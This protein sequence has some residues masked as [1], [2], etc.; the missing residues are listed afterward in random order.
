[1]KNQAPSK[2]GTQAGNVL[3]Y[4]LLAIFLL[5]ALTM[6]MS[7]TGSQS[8]DT[9]SAEKASI[10]ASEILKYAAGIKTAVDLL[11]AQGCSETQLSFWNDHNKDGT[12]NASD[13]FYN[14]RSPTDRTCHLFHANGAGISW[15]K[16]KPEWLD[17]SQNAKAGYGD[18]FFSAQSRIVNIGTWC[19]T[20]ACNEIVILL[21]Y[22]NKE[23]CKRINQMLNVNPGSHEPPKDDNSAYGYTSPYAFNGTFTGNNVLNDT[24]NFLAG[25]KTGCFEGDLNPPGGYHFYHVLLAR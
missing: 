16:V 23:T 19:A 13:L 3:W 9:G 5:G 6:F 10:H 15:R 1:M 4:I 12:E 7:N 2:A 22:L 17:K 11:M 8:E 25:K 24:T 20:P 14:S 18:W 21:P